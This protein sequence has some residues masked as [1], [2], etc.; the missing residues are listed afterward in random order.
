[1]SDNPFDEPD[2]TDR[3]IMR[4]PAPRPPA[5]APMP[6]PGMAPP[7][8]APSASA[9]AVS[10]PALAAG[11]ESVPHVGIGPI[12]AAAAPLLEMGARIANGGMT[13]TPNPDELHQ[14]TLAALRAFEKDSQAAGASPEEMRE[15]HYILCA[16]L[17][18]VVLSTPW[19][20][21]SG[22][23]VRS[24]GSTFHQDVRSGEHVFDRLTAM[25]R[26]PGKWRGVLEVGYMALA[27]GLQ[28]KYRL[29][30]QGPAE[31]ERFRTSLYQLLT[32]L[33]GTTEKELS[34]HWRGVDAPHR[35][36]GTGVPA[37]VAIPVALALIGGAWYWAAGSNGSRA[38]D[39]I[40]RIGALPP[41][42]Q[43][44][45][46][47]AAIVRPPEPP[48]APPPDVPPPLDAARTLRR[49][50]APEIQQR[51]VYVED[52]YQHILVRI[53]GSGM[54]PS[55]S[56]AL[57]PAFADIM[58][59]IGEALKEEPGAVTVL[60]HSDNQPIR[61][62][63]FPSNMALSAARAEAA[64]DVIRRA[65]GDAARFR[66]EGRADQEPIASNATAEGRDANRRIEVLLR[67]GE[68]R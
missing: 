7:G 51:L 28:G 43:P 15:A 22:W 30:P 14:R 36:P 11:A 34:P 61:T 17:D 2:D 23:A 47:R 21:R 55:G 29:A 1:M 20:A 44:E 16:M 46:A 65:N 54:F 40:G 4:G 58:R 25:Q 8:V 62:A 66:S 64:M 9:P 59:R 63:R 45:I 3:T 60:G 57:N 13:A 37:W 41:S 19:G 18:D 48:P 33:R 52:D 38:D 35:R 50:L 49:F 56:A 27:L 6:Q 5:P 68:A 67:R 24:L 53:A 42:T 26:E 39:L 32:G 10:A 31:L 12:A